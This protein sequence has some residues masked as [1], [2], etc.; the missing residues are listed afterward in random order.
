MAGCV[1]AD[2]A[3]ALGVITALD[4]GIVIGLAQ[5]FAAE[6]AC[7]AGGVVGAFGDAAAVQTDRTGS[8]L[9]IKLAGLHP[10]HRVGFNS[11]GT[12]LANHA[13]SAVR[14]IATFGLD[15]HS[16]DAI[17]TDV[18]GGAVAQVLAAN[19]LWRGLGI[20]AGAAIGIADLALG[21]LAGCLA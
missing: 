5:P 1:D 15:R 14:V 19:R 9:I 4:G 3:I 11:A 10:G 13:L 2:A 21:A 7:G 20:D 17:V 8:T 18:T 12:V 16:A 6:A